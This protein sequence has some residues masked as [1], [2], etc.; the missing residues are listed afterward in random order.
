M[1][2]IFHIYRRL[3]EYDFFRLSNDLMAQKLM[4]SNIDCKVIRYQ[5]MDHGFFDRLGYCPQT[6][7]CILEIAKQVKAL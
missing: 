6:T 4:N 2:R 5:G 1:Q 3:S 7:D